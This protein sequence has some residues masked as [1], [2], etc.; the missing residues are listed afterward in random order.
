M[1]INYKRGRQN[2]TINISPFLDT[3][4]VSPYSWNVRPYS[5]MTWSYF[6]LPFYVQVVRQN[7]FEKII[8]FFGR[9][10]IPLFYFLL[11][12]LNLSRTLIKIRFWYASHTSIEIDLNIEY[13][14]LSNV[15]ITC[16]QNDSTIALIFCFSSVN[17]S[18]QIYTFT[19]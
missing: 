6:F 1:W 7:K 8:W 17:H 4:Q 9:L 5:H 11:Y 14:L 15:F 13:L 3:C 16:N 12:I 10:F 19:N 2:N 18:N